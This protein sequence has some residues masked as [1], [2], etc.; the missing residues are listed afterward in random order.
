MIV[1]NLKDYDHKPMRRYS[2]FNKVFS[3][4]QYR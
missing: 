4:Y 1:A 3:K 2:K